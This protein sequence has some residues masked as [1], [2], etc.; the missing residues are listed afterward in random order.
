MDIDW[1]QLALDFVRTNNCA[2][3]ITKQ[4]VAKAMQEGAAEGLKYSTE[5]MRDLRINL[6]KKQK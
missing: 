5:K 1:D 6:Q 4:L 2:S 3:Y